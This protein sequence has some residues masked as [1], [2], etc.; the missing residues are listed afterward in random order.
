RLNKDVL[1]GALFVLAGS[2]GLWI[3]QDYALGTAFR[4][5]P[6]YFPRLLCSLLVLLGLFIAGKGIVLGG[7][8]PEALHLR[9]L[10]LITAAVI[11][12]GGLIGT[13]GLAPATIAVVLIGAFAGP[14]FRPLEGCLLALCL[15]AAAVGLFKYG[16][17]MTMPIA[18]I[19]FLGL[20][21]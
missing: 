11:S 20:K 1:S 3:G 15:A 10:L 9:P 4:M 2:A 12:F 7:E 6:G 5:G 16:L 18:D 17:N 19:P 14:E 21:L 13:V 8:R